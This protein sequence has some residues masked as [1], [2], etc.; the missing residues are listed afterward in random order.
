MLISSE[1]QGLTG[2]ARLWRA[3]P[4]NPTPDDNSA[5]LPEALD[6]TLAEPKRASLLFSSIGKDVTVQV[7]RGIG[8]DSEDATLPSYL[9]RNCVP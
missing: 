6:T 5:H 1:L 7:Y 2:V 9:C 3:D 8:D 4:I